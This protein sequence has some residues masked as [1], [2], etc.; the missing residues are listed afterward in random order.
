MFSAPLHTF[1][2]RSPDVNQGLSEFKFERPCVDI[3]SHTNDN[4]WF[5]KS[6]IWQSSETTFAMKYVNNAILKKAEICCLALAV[7]KCKLKP[8]KQKLEKK[9][10]GNNE[11]FNLIKHVG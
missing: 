1:V 9:L 3:P 4:S 5:R 2:Y 10:F 7:F 11:P 6:A 8:K